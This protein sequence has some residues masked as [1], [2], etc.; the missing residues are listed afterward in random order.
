MLRVQFSDQVLPLPKQALGFT[1][2]NSKV[3]QHTDYFEPISLEISQD[4]IAM[5]IFLY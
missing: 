2:R 3:K 4:V 5:I 1:P